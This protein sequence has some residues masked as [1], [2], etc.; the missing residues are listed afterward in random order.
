MFVRDGARL[1]TVQQ[2][3]LFMTLSIPVELVSIDGD[4]RKDRDSALRLA[5][6][7]LS[8]PGFSGSALAPTPNHL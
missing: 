5:I 4:R 8:P 7:K 2:K 1:N 6:A 3:S